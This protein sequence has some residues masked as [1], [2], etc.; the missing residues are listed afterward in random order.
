MPALVIVCRQDNRQVILACCGWA[1]DQGVRPDM[2][3]ANARALLGEIGAGQQIV[4]A[5]VIQPHQPARDRQA[6]D[7]LAQWALRFSPLVEVDPHSHLA[8]GGLL[9]DITGCQ[10]LFHGEPNLLMQMMDSTRRLGLESRVASAGTLGCAWA[11]AHFGRRSMEIVPDGGESQ[12][13]ADLPASAL[14]LDDATVAGLA[15]VGLRFIGQ[16]LTVPP[17]A[18]RERFGPALPKRIE[19]A[20]GQA[21]EAIKAVSPASVPRAELELAGPVSDLAAVQLGVRHLLA[22]LLSQLA[23]RQLGVHRLDLVV[24]R[25]D[26]A[27][28]ELTLRLAH[29]S[30]DE[31]HLWKL[32]L[33]QVERINMGFGVEALYLS[34]ADVALLE[35]TQMPLL[36]EV[37]PRG[38]SGRLS[39]HLGELVDILASR[40]GR[41]GVLA[42]EPVASHLPERAFAPQ[43]A[44]E[45]LNRLT[46]KMK[47]AGRAGVSRKSGPRETPRAT[48]CTPYGSTAEGGT[49]SLADRPSVLLGRPELIHVTALSPDGPV[50]SFRWKADVHLVRT[51][52]GPE[53]IA[54]QW[55]HLGD[56][57]VSP[58][59]RRVVS[60]LLFPDPSHVQDARG[61][62][63]EYGHANESVTMPPTRMAMAPA[64]ANDPLST[65]DYFKLQDQAGRWFWLYRQLRDN[66]WYIHGFWE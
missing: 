63:G 2:P 33:P 42:I 24:K 39:R 9:L 31:M 30:G 44:G 10:R 17:S 8:Q 1:Q 18:L 15:E 11:M 22:K 25:S 4:P 20:L 32:L 5:Y 7:V 14:R 21:W 55:W 26:A 6:L 43:P 37:L 54:P 41:E 66:R 48:S 59:R 34:A 49:A 3:L 47:S 45:V 19:Q 50:A 51:C 12:V 58:M 61:M 65:R 56:M 64:A 36:P 35:Q 38:P 16:L 52:F 29:A 23:P 13:L 60:T 46:K 28:L 27:P 40:V 62:H 57:S 53:R